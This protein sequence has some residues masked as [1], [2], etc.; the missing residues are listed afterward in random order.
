MA[1]GSPPTN[2]DLEESQ[3]AETL[4]V[5]IP[6]AVLAVLAVCARFVA[7][8][9]Q[10]LR[11]GLDD[12]LMV[13]LGSGKHVA[14]VP[15]ENIPLYLKCLFAYELIYASAILTIKLCIL[16]FYRR[17]FAV[18]EFKILSSI[19][20]AVVIAW[21][22]AVV[23]VSIFSCHPI[24]GF[25]DATVK[26]RCI[27]TEAFFVG[28]AV[29]NIVTDIIILLLPIRMIWR[30]RVSKDQKLA[31]S[32]VFMLG[33]LVIISSCIRLRE[34]FK[35]HDPDF[36]WAMNGTVIWTS[37]EPSFAVISACLPTLRPLAMRIF[38][39]RF[40]SNAHSGVGQAYPRYT[41]GSEGTG[42]E[43][44]FNTSSSTSERD[45]R[46]KTTATSDHRTID[47][48]RDTVLLNQISV[49]KDIHLKSEKA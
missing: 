7:R 31:L 48:E 9:I 8:R 22:I 20:V 14:A 4:R 10:K 3:Q 16:S 43:R 1:A 5:I 28:N 15:L 25:W 27:N 19:V 18:A 6:F 13:Q 47:P 37:L 12:Y 35:V 38:P 29:P 33:G 46:M 36:T 11:Y 39:T 34:Q 40:S 45:C 24:N 44:G 21:W 17:I 30:L 23:L 2:V 42:S 41:A 32:F 49:R 26:P